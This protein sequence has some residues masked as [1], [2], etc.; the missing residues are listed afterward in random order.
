M[1]FHTDGNTL[2]IRLSGKLDSSSSESV[3]TEI[4]QCIQDHPG[5][6]LCLDLDQVEYITSSGIRVLLGLQKSHPGGVRIRNA[7]PE[8]Y[9]V[10]AITGV[11]T[12]MDIRRKPRSVSVEGCPVIGRGA[13]GTVYRLDRDTV[14]KVFSGGEASLPGMEKEL[15][16]AR[17]AFLSGIPTAIP[18]DIVRVGDQFG[19]V[20][21]MID[22]QNCNDCVRED[23]GVL[24]ELIPKYAA[25]LK[26]MHSLDTRTDNLREVRSSYLRY[27]EVISPHLPPA[28]GARLKELIE[29]MPQARHIIHGDIHLK[30][31]MIS[32]GEMI[33]I[34]MDHLALGDPVFEFAGL[35]AAYIAFNEDDPD[36]I[37]RFMGIDMQTGERIFHETLRAYLGDADE[38]TLR[39]ALLKVR[40]VGYL[41]FLKILLVEQADVHT[42]L[43]DLQIRHAAEH[44]AELVPQVTTLCL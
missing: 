12:L 42:A 43:H 14:V 9:E 34:D 4:R 31:I 44:L 11:T 37:F 40:T 41:R 10:L 38:S 20:F 17:Q 26:N 6:S 35:F 39:E 27:L 28:T 16:N 29:Q 2:V 13:F 3:N 15:A 36:D 22:A 18:F 1:D 21:E 25:L 5:L 33:L 23:P 19:V 30:N 7:S 24:D 8:V 32:R